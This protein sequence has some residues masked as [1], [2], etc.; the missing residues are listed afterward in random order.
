MALTKKLIYRPKLHEGNGNEYIVVQL[1]GGHEPV[2][3]GSIND[4]VYVLR[5]YFKNAV[6]RMQFCS[7]GGTLSY[8][9]VSCSWLCVT[10][11]EQPVEQLFN[12]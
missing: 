9:S 6:L 2:A 12:C 1:G 4:F 11:L 8:I 3:F 7:G 5:G 10:F